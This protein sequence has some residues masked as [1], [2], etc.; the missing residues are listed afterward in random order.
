MLAP[1]F[2]STVVRIDHVEGQAATVTLDAINDGTRW[3]LIN[4][5][6]YAVISTSPG[7]F[8]LDEGAAAGTWMVLIQGHEWDWAPVEYTLTVA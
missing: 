3:S 5:S 7:S 4:P 2:A 1:G 6:G 8:L